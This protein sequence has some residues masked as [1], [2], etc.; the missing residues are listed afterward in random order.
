MSTAA[1]LR[2]ALDA[3]TFTL[4]PGVYDGISAKIAQQTGFSAAYMTGS[5]VSASYGLPDLGLITQTEMVTRAAQLVDA[6]S[7]PLIADADTGYG[8]TLN[9]TRTVQLYERAGVAGIHIEDQGFPKKCGHLEN[10]RLISTA[11]YVTK[12]RA[13]LAARRDDNF[14][15]IARTDARSVEGIDAAIAR[16]KAYAKAGADCIF[17]ESP[18]SVEEVER[19]AHEVDAPLLFNVVARGKTPTIPLETVKALGFALAIVPGAASLAATE[20]I[21]ASYTE[22]ATHGTFSGIGS[23]LSPVDFFET[24]GLSQW[25]QIEKEYPEAE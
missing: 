18:E 2:A 25:T 16:A 22:L 21:T 12:L 7:I 6:L 24:V 9:V 1:T 23:T 11:A 14:V 10:K 13:A 20:A 4:A 5:G 8:N 15:L 3:R 17:V 19:I